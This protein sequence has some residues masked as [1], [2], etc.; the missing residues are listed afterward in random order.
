MMG[1]DAGMAVSYADVH[2]IFQL[3]CRSCHAAGHFTMLDLSGT[4]AQTY[5]EITGADP[6]VAGCEIA[7]YVTPGDPDASR[8][9]RKV[10]ATQP[11]T[12]G[13]PMPAGTPGLS[14]AE[15]ATIRAWIAAGASG[16]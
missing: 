14:A 6:M 15:A 5:A 9:Y 1:T 7:A 12:C 3:R 16:P 11:A 2:A 4:P 10:S 8:V 13:G